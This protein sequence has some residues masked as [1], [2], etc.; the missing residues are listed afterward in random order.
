MACRTI[1]YASDLLE[2]SRGTSTVASPC[3]LVK[4]AHGYTTI[5]YKVSGNP[6]R[7]P[8]AHLFGKQSVA[9]SRPFVSWS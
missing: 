1:E 3:P 2:A 7:D 4:L 8:L 5:A 6:W 9:L